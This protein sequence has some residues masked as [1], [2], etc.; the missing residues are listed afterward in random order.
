MDLMRVLCWNG[1]PF[2]NVAIMH[3]SACYLRCSL[4]AGRG[5]EGF[6]SLGSC[7]GFRVWA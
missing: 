2:G 6:H 3:G 5:A 7:L 1:G 4:R